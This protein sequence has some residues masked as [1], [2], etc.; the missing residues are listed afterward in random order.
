MDAHRVAEK[1]NLIGPLMEQPQYNMF[2]R[3][4]FE[5]E[6]SPLYEKFGLGT[7]IWSPLASG[8]LTGKYNDQ[9]PDDSR[10]NTTEH[11]YVLRLKAELQNEQG[12]AKIKKV[13]ALEP[14]AK[15]LDCTLAQLA[16]AWCAKNPNVSTVITGGSKVSQ[17][18]ENVK[19]LEV[20]PKLT[21]EIMEEIEKILGN[22]PVLDI[23]RW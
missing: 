3:D 10:L 18:Q 7:T 22:K 8:I 19:A 20:I 21:P 15:K 11:A 23:K 4:R 17:I 14:I 13:K 9:I 2:A 16:L 6:Y 12:I 1:L 5:K